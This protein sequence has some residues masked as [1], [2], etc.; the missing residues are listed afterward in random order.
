MPVAYKNPRCI[1]SGLFAKQH[2]QVWR[3]PSHRGQRPAPWCPGGDLLLLVTRSSQWMTI[4]NCISNRRHPGQEITYKL[5]PKHTEGNLPAVV[6]GSREP[7]RSHISLSLL[8]FLL[9]LISSFLSMSVGN[10]WIARPFDRQW[11]FIDIHGV[12]AA[13][14]S[15]LQMSTSLKLVDA[16]LPK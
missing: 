15:P 12:R 4:S 3:S 9:L 16:L 11:A 7:G 2:R 5:T 14:K 8:L 13:L 1:F 10:L 6:S